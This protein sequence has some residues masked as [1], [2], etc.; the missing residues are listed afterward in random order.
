MTIY[1]LLKRETTECKI[2]GNTIYAELKQ[3]LSLDGDNI[4]L[5]DNVFLKMEQERGNVDVLVHL[6][7]SKDDE[8]SHYKTENKVL[9]DILEALRFDKSNIVI[10]GI[11]EK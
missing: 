4:V 5:P 6:L 7:K 11:G 10:K 9:R 8:I 1:T 3:N 2:C